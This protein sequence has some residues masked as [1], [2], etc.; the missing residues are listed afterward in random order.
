[1]KKIKEIKEFSG[2]V[3][4][5]IKLRSKFENSLISL[6][7]KEFSLKFGLKK[8]TIFETYILYMC[9]GVLFNDSFLQSLLEELPQDALLS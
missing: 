5:V 4:E 6:I 9:L 2:L 3:I 7:F 8:S 1:M